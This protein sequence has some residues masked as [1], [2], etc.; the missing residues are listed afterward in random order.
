MSERIGQQLGNYRLQRL[1]GQ[2]GFAEVYLGE[3]IHLGTHA[4]IKLLYARVAQ[5]DLAI[6]KQ[7]A[8]TLANLIHPHIV[9]VLD[10]GVDNNTPYLVMDYAPGG[11]LRTRHPRGSRV[12]LP[13]V[14]EYVKQVAQALQYAHEQRLIHRDIKPENM[15]LGRNGEILLSDFGIAVISR[16]ERTSLNSLAGT[17]GTPYYM[18]PEMFQG[19]PRTASD[20]YSLGI[21][22]YEW[23]CGT[24][25]FNEGNA[26]QLGY[27]HTH[28]LTPPLRQHLPT[29]SPAVE[30][31]VM[32][33]LAKKP[34]ERFGAMRAF[35]TALEQASQERYTPLPPTPPRISTPLPPPSRISLPLPPPPSKPLPTIQDIVTPPSPPVKNV[36]GATPYPVEPFV[37]P[38]PMESVKQTDPPLPVQPTKTSEQTER[39]I[40]RRTVIIGAAALVTVS[41][42]GTGIWWFT[43]ASQVPQQTPFVTYRGHSAGV[44]SVSWSLD[45]KHIASAAWDNTVQVWNATD[46]SHPFIYHGHSANVNAAGWS[47]DGTR[48]ASG[49]ADNTVQVWNASDGSHPFTYGN[50]IGTVYAVG[51]SPDGK[52]MASASADKTVQIWNATDGGQPF[53]Y[54][55][56]NNTVYAVNWSPDGKR[57]A[58][59]SADMTVQV[60]NAADGSHALSYPGH[61][62]VVYAA[63]WSPDGTRIASGSADQTVQVWSAIN[64]NL[65]FTYRGHSG[66]VYSVAWSPDGKHLVSGSAD[67]TAQVW[68]ATN[69]SHTFTY[70]GHSAAVR[71]V[72]WSP[73]GTRIASGSEDNTVQV[74]QAV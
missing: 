46:G 27:Q 8:R 54:Q 64:G 40:S 31:V 55:G 34:E 69:G 67:N 74:W 30:Q 66:W 42:A 26:I 48:I 7:E 41:L 61:R 19:K 72:V 29:L 58:S 51:C 15:L 3:H 13:T 20:Q 44:A 9:R 60:W 5:D 49:S 62:D 33:A 4:A 71:S 52:R 70:D 14:V 45:G 38:Y 73:D 65:L 10:F 59:G 21:V 68:N 39:G 11:T 2:G 47:P 36:R 50:H 1:L 56:H 43:R 23:L 28:E 17:G 18:A 24:P 12:P 37:L 63:A 25:P 57:I 53:I 16:S 32:T 35:A 22:V 6:F